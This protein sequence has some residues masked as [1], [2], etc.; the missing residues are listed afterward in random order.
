MRTLRQ[1]EDRSIQ[2]RHASLVNYD[3]YVAVREKVVLAWREC[4]CA[5][6]SV[7]EAIRSALVLDVDTQRPGLGM[8]H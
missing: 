5:F 3:V 4:F 7:L 6:Y 2:E 1:K 8:R